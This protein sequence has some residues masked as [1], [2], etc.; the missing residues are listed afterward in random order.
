MEP[1]A[2]IGIG[3]RFPGGIAT[4]KDFWELLRNGVDAITEVP[5]DRYDIDAYYDPHPATPGKVMSRFGG[6]L[7]QVDRF[8]AGFFGIAPREAGKIDPQH[9]L[10]LEVAWDA[11]EDAG[12]IPG[13]MSE[14]MRLGIGCFIG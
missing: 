3:C 5:P 12:L 2:I 13:E 6:F 9:R 1:I 11:M 4:L 14:E 7:D 10:L 8:D